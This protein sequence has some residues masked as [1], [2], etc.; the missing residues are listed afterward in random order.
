MLTN[1]S[2]ER[3][4]TAR[5]ELRRACSLLSSP[6]PDAMAACGRAL[7]SAVAELQVWLHTAKPATSDPA[8]LVEVTELRQSVVQAQRLLQA[9]ADYHANW[10][11]Q[12]CIMAGGYTGEGKPM[13]VSPAS[14]VSLR[15]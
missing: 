14:R 1:E 4:R 13:M 12:I 8:T 15:A 5:A 7:K 10:L 3:V 9:A 2:G 11:Q 6:S